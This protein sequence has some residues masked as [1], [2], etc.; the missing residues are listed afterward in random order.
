MTEEDKVK[1]VVISVYKA[2]EELDADK[3]DAFFSHSDELLAFGQQWS[4][5]T[6]S[7]DDISEEHKREFQQ[8]QSMKSTSNEL[9]VHVRGNV[10]WTADRAHQVVELKN[11]RKAENDLRMTL[12]LERQSAGDPWSIIQ[13]HVSRGI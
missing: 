1:D 2:I 5:R 11:G 3:L 9:E 12:V 10:A 8:V 6:K 13:W 7:I 4:S